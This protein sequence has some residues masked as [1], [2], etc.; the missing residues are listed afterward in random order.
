M[1]LA[2]GAVVA[3]AIFAVMGLTVTKTQPWAES[4]N[5]TAQQQANDLDNI[6]GSLFGRMVVPFEVLGILLT[7]AMIG[8]LVIAR[9]MEAP[10]DESRYSHPTTEQVA[11]SD[12][13]SDVG[14]SL[15]M[16]AAA[17]AAAAKEPEASQ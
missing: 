5:A 17:D 4:G 6:T 11:E 16:T 14:H 8:A 3:I 15:A 7:A 1:T 2:L 9:P 10:S 12:R 13:A